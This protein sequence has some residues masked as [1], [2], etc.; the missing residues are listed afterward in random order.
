ML[1]RI[2]NTISALSLF[3]DVLNVGQKDGCDLLTLYKEF[4]KAVAKAS[5]SG[6]DHLAALAENRRHLLLNP[7]IHLDLFVNEQNQLSEASEG[8][9]HK[10]LDALGVPEFHQYVW[11]REFHSNTIILRRLRIFME[12]KLKTIPVSEAAVERCL[13]P[14]NLFILL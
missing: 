14:T 9:L 6:R 12:R 2:E 1:V 3:I 10:W 5:E 13:V 11:E 4:S 8:R 7:V